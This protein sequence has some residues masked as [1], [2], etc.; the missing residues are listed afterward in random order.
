MALIVF[1]TDMIRGGRVAR[2]GGGM[3]YHLIRAEFRRGERENRTG[4]RFSP[5]KKKGGT[6]HSGSEEDHQKD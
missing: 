4:Y 5:L 6:A 2:S 1:V 3:V